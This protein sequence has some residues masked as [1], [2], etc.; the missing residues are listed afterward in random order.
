MTNLWRLWV[1]C[2]VVL[3]AC[4]SPS[5]ASQVGTQSPSSSSSTAPRLDIHEALIEHLV[6]R[7]GTQ[8][9]YVVPDLCFQLMEPT[10]GCPDQLS[11]GEQ[12]ELSIRLQDLGD[13]VFVSEDGTRPPQDQPFQEI[14]LGPIVEK[15]EGIRVEG[16]VVCGGTCGSGAV[17]SVAASPDGCEVVGTDDSYGAWVS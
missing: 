2:L 14:V 6:D 3:A 15:A 8:P 10:R 12:R 7:E 4:A 9:I 5:A 17:Y 11:K 16:G 1:G 13:I